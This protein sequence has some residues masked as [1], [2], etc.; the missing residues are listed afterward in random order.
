MKRKRDGFGMVETI[1]VSIAAMVY[2]LA[3]RPVIVHVI[4]MLWIL[5]GK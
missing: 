3:M 5:I 2:L 1:L 4:R